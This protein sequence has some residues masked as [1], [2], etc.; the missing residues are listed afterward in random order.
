MGFYFEAHDAIGNVVY[1]SPFYSSTS[2]LEIAAKDYVENE[3]VPVILY[4]TNGM[5]L[6]PIGKVEYDSVSDSAQVEW[7]EL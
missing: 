2:D 4:Q 6:R 5:F 7:D 1:K 3:G